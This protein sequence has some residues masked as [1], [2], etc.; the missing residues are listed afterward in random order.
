MYVE[1]AVVRVPQ[2]NILSR[3]ILG[4]RMVNVSTVMWLV[5]RMDN[6]IGECS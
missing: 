3:R 4:S 1:H 2:D 6:A 5:M